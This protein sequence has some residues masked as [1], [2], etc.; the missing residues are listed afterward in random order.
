[1]TLKARKKRGDELV[2]KYQ[3]RISQDRYA[4]A[5]DLIADTLLA[6]AT[7]SADAAKILHAAEVEYRNS[8]EVEEFVSEG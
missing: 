6:V 5:A 2:A 7:N 8:A 4:A 3:T 1:M